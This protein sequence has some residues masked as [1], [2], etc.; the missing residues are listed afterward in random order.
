M[1]GNAHIG[2]S[3]EA[4]RL[5]GALEEQLAARG[6]R[7]ELVVIGGSALLA[8]GLVSRVTQDV[9]VVALAD[10][11]ELLEAVPLPASLV[12][13]ATRVARDFGLPADW[14]NSEAA[15]DM[16]RLGL[17]Q[18]FAERLTARVYGA[19]LTVHYASRLDQIHL[20]LHAAVDH[21][22]PSKHLAD[23]EALEP[24][25]EELVLAARWSRT[26]DPSEGYL[27]VL[28]P[29]LEYLGAKDADLGD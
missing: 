20:K 22:G 7:F 29:A 6:E 10:G 1:S 24:T 27:S 2:S 8:L 9:D 3:C 14:L 17:P 26:H 25:S 5:L 13:A 4:D 15:R 16:L 18:G 11:S 23:L 19:G 12:E 28:V 21:G